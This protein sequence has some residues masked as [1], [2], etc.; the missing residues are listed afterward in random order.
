MAL[1]YF[2][3]VCD[4]RQIKP[5][6]GFPAQVTQSSFTTTTTYTGVSYVGPPNILNVT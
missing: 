2:T 4:T 3:E 6:Q 5:E 1:I